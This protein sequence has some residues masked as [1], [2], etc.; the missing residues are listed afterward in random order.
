MRLMEKKKR[1]GIIWFILLLS[2]VSFFTSLVV[3]IQ[4]VVPIFYLHFV[5]ALFGLFF[6]FFISYCL[7]YKIWGKPITSHRTTMLSFTLI[8][9]AD[10]V[11]QW[12][13][14]ELTAVAFPVFFF[15]KIFQEWSFLCKRLFLLRWFF[16][17][18]PIH[19]Q[20]LES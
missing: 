6:S 10:I 20:V 13:F 16:V 15:S 2:F 8:I 9:F 3:F 14:A 7:R 19:K 18:Y 5:T 17:L 12:C 1:N 4:G 11:F